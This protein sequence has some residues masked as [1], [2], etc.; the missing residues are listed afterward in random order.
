MLREYARYMPYGLAVAG[1]FLQIIAAP[2]DIF[3]PTEGHSV[4]DIL[5]EQRIE[6]IKSDSF[7]TGGEMIDRELRALVVD[8][9]HL[10]SQLNMELQEM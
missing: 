1:S 4:D 9:Y 3:S 2:K 5:D 10:Y 6:E 8:M 7:A